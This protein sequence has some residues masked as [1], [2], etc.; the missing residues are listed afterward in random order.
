V[1]VYDKFKARLLPD[2]WSQQVRRWTEEPAQDLD[3]LDQEALSLLQRDTFAKHLLALSKK[4]EPPAIDL[5]A[6]GWMELMK[7]EQRIKAAVSDQ[8][9]RR[10][11]A[12]LERAGKPI[13]QNEISFYSER[14]K[15][16]NIQQQLRDIATEQIEREKQREIETASSPESAT[17]PP[18]AEQMQ[19][20][21][22]MSME[23]PVIPIRS[24]KK[25]V[26]NNIFF[27]PNSENLKESSFPE[28]D[29]IL[30]LLRREPGINVLLTVHTHGRCSHGFAM[31]LSEAR[32]K[33]LTDYFYEKGIS[34]TQL[35]AIGWGK[36]LPLT[37]DGSREK[38]LQN[39]RVELH[40]K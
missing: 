35:E 4:I 32:A 28:L 29:R 8:L 6:S 10:I 21:K 36:L 14:E 33:V 5:V 18:P 22:K 16:N 40:I 20:S 30:G 26:L 15:Y 9:N 23:I 11:G 1:R 25:V 2:L 3:D 19:S 31:N 37:T 34:R 24:G 27:E 7:I 17:P 12:L 39:Q 13:L 38:M